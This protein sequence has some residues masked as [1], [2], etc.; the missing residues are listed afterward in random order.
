MKKLTIAIDGPSGVG[1]SS[2]GKALARRF[3]YQYIDSG[4]VYRAVGRKALDLGVS[5]D[6]AGAVA[7]LARAAAVRFEGD[8]DH[9]KVFLDGRDVTTE[10]RLP[11]ASR[12]ASVI[13]TI[14]EVREAVVEKL[15]EMSREGGVV[16]DGRDIGTRVF[17]EA[18]LKLFLEA[19]PEERARRR[20]AEERGRGRE[21]S[22]EQVR[23]ELEERDRR[24]R[25]RTATPLV[26]AEDAVLIDTSN[27]PLDRVLDSVLDI[28][29]SRS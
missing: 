16:M 17:P 25:E 5:L 13:A 8:P 6:E 21:V 10:I 19:S 11:D 3:G 1:K 28:V 18:E 29:N 14:A 4:A 24:D 22:V 9:L 15:R 27:T 7:R 12:A 20:W 2:L 23:A 26:R